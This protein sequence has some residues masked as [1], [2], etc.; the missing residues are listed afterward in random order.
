MISILRFNH[1][2]A[3]SSCNTFTK[4]FAGIDG[5]GKRLADEVSIT[6]YVCVCVFESVSQ[7]Y[8]TSVCESVCVLCVRVRVPVLT[9]YAQA[10]KG[11]VW[12]AFWAVSLCK[13]DNKFKPT[14]YLSSF[15]LL[16]NIEETNTRLLSSFSTDFAACACGNKFLVIYYVAVNRSCK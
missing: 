5:A 4:T 13:Q 2:C 7:I 8:S 6:S 14:H 3:A 10:E 12:F 15:W 9:V 16:L 1:S 11:K